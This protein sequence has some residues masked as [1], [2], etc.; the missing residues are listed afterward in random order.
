MHWNVLK[1][2]LAYYDT[3]TE[4]KRCSGWQKKCAY[5]IKARNKHALPLH[6]LL[7]HSFIYLRDVAA[8]AVFLL[9]FSKLVQKSIFIMDLCTLN[10]MNEWCRWKNDT[11]L[12]S[13]LI[14]IYLFAPYIRYGGLNSTHKV[15]LMRIL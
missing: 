14:V 5:N 8:A 10:P 13:K 1:W 3:N 4:S 6:W 2:Q 12:N 11:E 9:S 7:I 15:S